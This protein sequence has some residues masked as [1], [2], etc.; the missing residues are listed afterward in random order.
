MDSDTLRPARG[1]AVLVDSGRRRWWRSEPAPLACSLLLVTQVQRL[2]GT[3]GLPLRRPAPG[4]G[5][6]DQHPEQRFQLAPP[7]ISQACRTTP[8]CAD[9]PAEGIS[10][11]A[12]PPTCPGTGVAEA[13]SSTIRWLTR[14]RTRSVTES[15]SR[16][17]RTSSCLADCSVSRTAW[18]SV[19]AAQGPACTPLVKGHPASA[20]RKLNVLALSGLEKDPKRPV[21]VS[22]PKAVEPPLFRCHSAMR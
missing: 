9:S 1:L 14:S 18:C 10:I 12:C 17:A 5:M 3:T 16:S 20:N 11:T 21:G 19:A 22:A 6:P 15:S 13:R 8:R 4:G 2:L 7:S